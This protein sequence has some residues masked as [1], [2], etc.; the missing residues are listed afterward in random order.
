MNIRYKFYVDSREMNPAI[1]SNDLSIEI[2]PESGQE[3]ARRKLSGTL[4]FQREDFVFLAEKSIETEMTLK[5]TRSKDEGAFA[6]YYV[7]KFSKT[8]C[9]WNYD[10][11]TVSIKVETD[12]GY[13]D[14]LAGLDKEFDLIKLAPKIQKCMI[15]KRPCVQLH[16]ENDSSVTSYASGTYWEQD[17]INDAGLTQNM[18]A[19]SSFMLT[20]TMS[21]GTIYTGVLYRNN[22]SS[23]TN[24]EGTA[25][26]DKGLYRMEIA[27]NT[28]D[29]SGTTTFKIYGINNGTL[30]WEGETYAGVSENGELLWEDTIN[31]QMVTPPVTNVTMTW[32]SNYIQSRI[33]TDRQSMTGYDLYRITSEDALEINPNYKYGAKVSF[34]NVVFVSARK[35]DTPNKWGMD[36]NGKYFLPPEDEGGYLPLSKSNWTNSSYWFKYNDSVYEIDRI[37]RNSFV[38]NDAYPI[39]SVIQ[40]LLN[41]I[42]PGITHSNTTAYSQFLY[43]ESDPISHKDINLIMTPTSNVKKAGYDQ[44]AMKAPITLGE[45]LSM[46]YN[47][48]KLKWHIKDSKLII[49]HIQYYY[50]GG[51]YDTEQ[52]IGL[53]LTTTIQPSNNK[54]W[55]MGQNSF[56]YDKENAPERF[57]FSWA[58]D[59]TEPFEGYPIEVKSNAVQKGNIEEI[60]VGKFTSDIDFILSNPSMISDDGFVVMSCYYNST[61]RQYTLPFVERTI[62]GFTY[63]LQNGYLAYI[64]LQPD[65]WVYDM[66]GRTLMINNAEYVAQSVTR[67][68]KQSIKFPTYDDIDP[69][70]LVKTDLGVGK[71]DKCTVSLGTRMNNVTLK[72]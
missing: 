12:D 72:Y 34:S 31:M 7:S 68:M 62:D 35:T 69:M 52:Q 11:R 50:N 44:P 71:I 9:S 39:H 22:V 45:V 13:T 63:N 32:R 33:L 18:W 37:G 16:I 47:T 58:N 27:M 24:Y 29:T 65:Y 15:V 30:Y 59:V 48:F 10:N 56:E 42:A 6:D 8:D 36:S 5:I 21:N 3:F 57:Q 55:G 67:K 1:Y 43:S 17:V 70:T 25:Y 2:S 14:V 66:P 4:V 49:E 40:V 64:V 19:F 38:L 26:D 61:L 20:F 54:P 46:L 28:V 53:D 23:G 51:T 41:E 60:T